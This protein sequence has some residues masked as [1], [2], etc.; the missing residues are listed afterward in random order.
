MRRLRFLLFLGGLGG[1][2]FLV[3]RIGP[4]SLGAAFAQLRWWQFVLVCLPYGL[5][6]VVDTLGWRYAFRSDR[7]PFHRLLGAR[8]AGDALN[9]ATALA[10]VGGE[11]MKVWLIRR[12]VPY[13]DSVPALV[14]AKTTATVAQALFLLVGIGLAL[15]ALPLES[16][17]VRVMFWLLVVEVVAV[18][19]FVLVQVTGLVRRGGRLLQWFGIDGG[20]SH[21]DR[22]DRALRDYYR[23]NWRRFAVS[24]SFHFLGWLL[25]A[26]ETYLMLVALG[27]GVPLVTASVVEAFGSGVR[28]AS[29][30][31]P[32]NIGALE[33][34]NAAV[35][36][37]L[38]LTGGAG[39]AFTL[40]RRGRQ[41]VWV[42][43]G[44]LT[45]VGMRSGVWVRARR[46]P[47]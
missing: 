16:R 20:A 26:V 19:G 3:V 4:E 43:I 32:A 22:L 31:V 27:V 30:L 17:V 36:G 9:V 6:M 1:L 29:F 25:G 2:V 24:T 13:E 40:V 18:G 45:L 8:M 42:V 44:L 11:A 41:V 38:G 7:A 12:D 23:R 28:F 15:A 46:S 47:A 21:A 5:I 33:G 37:A 34:A 14:I 39:L 10:S 35:F